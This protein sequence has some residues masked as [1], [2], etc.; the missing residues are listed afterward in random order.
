[1]SQ[2]RLTAELVKLLGEAEFIRLA[3]RY[4]GTRL[5]VASSTASTVARELGATNAELLAERY[6]GSYIRVPLARER[7]ARHYRECMAL[8]NAE[9]ARRL[10]LTESGVDRL[11][12]RMSDKPAKGSRDPRQAELFPD[13]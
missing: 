7:R 12:Q 11:F 3:E 8:S 6:A 1:M 9:I 5:Y 13:H 2:E 4:G 10:G